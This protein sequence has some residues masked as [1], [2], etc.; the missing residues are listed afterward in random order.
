LSIQEKSY[1]ES[2]ESCAE[3]MK[4]LIFVQLKLKDFEGALKTLCTLEDIQMELSDPN[5]EALSITR[6]LMGQVNYQVLKYPSTGCGIFTCT[7]DP[8]DALD[9]GSWLPKKPHNSSKMSGHRIT[10]A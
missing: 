6:R 8:D 9:F 1:A 4:K 3:T 5:E 2:Q 10:Y 7:S